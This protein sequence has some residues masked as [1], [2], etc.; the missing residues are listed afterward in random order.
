M[1]EKDIKNSD[2]PDWKKKRI[3]SKYGNNSFFQSNPT[4]DDLADIDE[5]LRELENRVF[6]TA[7][8]QITNRSQQI[9]LLNDLGLMDKINQLGISTKKKAYL[10]SVLLNASQDNIKDDL[11]NMYKPNYKH[12]NIENNEFLLKVYKEAGLKELIEKTDKQLDELNSKK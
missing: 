6:K 12:N 10:L 8:K 5:R 3:S 9:L 11:S 1:I 2:L 4:Y 7:R